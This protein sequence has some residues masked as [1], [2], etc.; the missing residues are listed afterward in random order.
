MS[1]DN[2]YIMTKDLH[3]I[4]FPNK[5]DRF[6]P[7]LGIFPEPR[8]TYL[9]K[10]FERKPIFF[11]DN[12]SESDDVSNEYTKIEVSVILCDK[13]R[14]HIYLIYDDSR[15]GVFLPGGSIRREDLDTSYMDTESILLTSLMRNI[16]VQ[17]D[18]V[19]GE[20]I[21]YTMN[22]DVMGTARSKL[23]NIMYSK[24]TNVAETNTIYYSYLFPNEKK[25]KFIIYYVFEFMPI[26]NSIYG[27]MPP[28][29]AVFL[30]PLFF[31]AYMSG[32]F[33]KG[34]FKTGAVCVY[35]VPFQEDD[36]FHVRASIA[37][38]MEKYHD[39]AAD[40]YVLDSPDQQIIL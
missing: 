17:F 15:N 37:K 3:A 28:L 40:V 25:R 1:N 33:F 6:T 30:N 12:F 32:R 27:D 18:S 22:Y 2:L 21:Y 23:T 26:H 29:H 10:L 36:V 9:E 11:R 34:G 16:L 35:H 14:N 8:E 38:D 20:S 31:H 5:Q 39:R 4:L 24:F 19:Y 7:K 13:H